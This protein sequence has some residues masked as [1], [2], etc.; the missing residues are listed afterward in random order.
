MSHTI[1]RRRFVQ[2]GVALGAA[3]GLGFVPAYA[4]EEE[5][6]AAAK[7]EG[8]L[9]LYWGSYE[10]KTAEEFRDA[11]K[12]RYPGIDVSL[13]RQGSQTVYNRLRLELQ[14]GVAEC[15]SLGTTNILHFIELKKANALLAYEPRGAD[16][17]PAGVRRLDPDNMFSVGAISLTSMNYQS[18]KVRKPPAS[19]LGLL[20]D[21]WQG[22]ITIGSPAA[23][24]DVASWVVAMRAKYGDDFLR[25][26]ARQR[27][28]I[29]QSN[30]DT[31]TDILSGERLVGAAAPFSFTLAQKAAGNPIDV[32]VPSDDLILNLGVMGIPK[33]APHPNAARLYHNFL[34]SQEASRMLSKNFWPTL[35]TDVAWADG[36]SLDT[37]KWYRNKPE[38]LAEQVAEGIAKWKEIM[39]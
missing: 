23:S 7:K 33:N 25:K 22:K 28:K 1:S 8:Q 24:G 9:S 2:S 31:V 20:D 27:P 30:V 15:D 10:Q 5:L 14:N 36:R 19:W 12:A 26:L 3:A 38:G 29:G 34:Y 6:Y 13:L 32:A 35:R 37:I 18:A 16:M 39:R 17:V 21:E 4:Q 11:F